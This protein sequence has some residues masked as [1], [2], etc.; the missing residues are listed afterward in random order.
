MKNGLPKMVKRR[1]GLLK[2]LS[3]QTS[4][5]QKKR[6]QFAKEI[7]KKNGLLKKKTEEEDKTSSMIRVDRD[8]IRQHRFVYTAYLCIPHSSFI[9]SI[10]NKRTSKSEQRDKDFLHDQPGPRTMSIGCNDKQY[11][12]MLLVFASNTN[13]PRHTMVMEEVYVPLF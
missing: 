1:T 11:T 5:S 7:V 9:H 6:A 13:L 4:T 8:W 2:S 12:A 3:R 10:R